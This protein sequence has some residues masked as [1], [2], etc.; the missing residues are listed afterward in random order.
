[1]IINPADKLRHISTYY[2]ARKLAEIREMNADGGA[3]VINL[4]IGSPDLDPPAEVI[5]ALHNQSDEIGANQYQSY[6]GIPQLRESYVG[7]YR[8]HFGVSLDSETEILPL[9]GSKE[10]IMHISMAFLNPGD[11]VLVPNPG[12]PAYTAVTKLCEAEVIEYKL[13][14][15]LNWLPDLGQLEKT[16]LS[17]V[18][19][20][21]VNYP[22][23]PTGAKA[24]KTF[25]DEL[26][27]FG[28]RN[29]I[30]ICHDNPY[31]F[32]LNEEPLSIMQSEGAKEVALELTSLSKNY[33]MAGWRVGAVAGGKDYID[34]ILTFKS[35][36]DSG[37][38]K[39][40]Q[41]AAIEALNQPQNWHD[42]LNNQYQE[43]R[44]IAWEIMDALE[45]KYDRSTSGLFIWGRIP[46]P[47][48][49]A[50]EVSE[51]YLHKSRVFITPGHIF[52]SEGNRYI[53]I[54]LCADVKTLKKA[55]EK[56]TQILNP[57]A[58]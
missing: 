22:H 1:M 29:N 50:E 2:F 23:M 53:R 20:M 51:L 32:I 28:K 15:D 8:R 14:A 27:A 13:N 9:I 18:K 47:A 34:T 5:S 6:R 7:W 36:M 55:K 46:E 44:E 24:S 43:R 42:H 10:G 45:C 11:Q 21:W 3:T 48:E 57:S 26:V 56:I 12:Y 16:D 41:Y 39:P 35:N 4:G 19:I 37:M 25:F 30:L 38:Y 52:G 58:I 17:K 54:S 33:N 31:T 49:G 40:V